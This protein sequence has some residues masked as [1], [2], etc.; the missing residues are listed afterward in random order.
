MTERAILDEIQ[1]IAALP[2]EEMTLED[3]MRSHDLKTTLGIFSRAR[4]PP[5]STDESAMPRFGIGRTGV[6]E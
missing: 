5:K 4:L 3:A 2:P 1:S 6:F